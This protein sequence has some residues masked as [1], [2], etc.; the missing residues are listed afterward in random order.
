[1][2]QNP[3][4]RERCGMSSCGFYFLLR[5]E[6]NQ[7]PVESRKTIEG[8]LTRADLGSQRLRI[9]IDANRTSRGTIRDSYYV[10][11]LEA[12]ARVDNNDDCIQ[13]FYCL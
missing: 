10:S 12:L 6:E 9:E 7:R 3:S 1:M 8:L 4:M 2:S 5:W 13:H 11:S